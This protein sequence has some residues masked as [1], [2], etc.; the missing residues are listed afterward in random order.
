[1]EGTKRILKYILPTAHSSHKVLMPF[2]AEILSLQVQRG[3]ITIW[4][5]CSETGTPGMRCFSL[6]E[7]SQKVDGKGKFVGTA[8]LND[9]Y[10]VLHVFDEGYPDE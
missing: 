8:L 10:Y 5:L 1:M 9:G 2:G 3:E 7:T 4:A 6:Y